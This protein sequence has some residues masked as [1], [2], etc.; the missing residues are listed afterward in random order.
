MENFLILQF[1][2]FAHKSLGK[3]IPPSSLCSSSIWFP[4]PFTGSDISPSLS[5][6]SLAGTSNGAQGHSCPGQATAGAREERAQTLVCGSA[7]E[8]TGAGRARGPERRAAPGDGARDPGGSRQGGSRALGAEASEA[9]RASGSGGCA[10]GGDVE[11]ARAGVGQRSSR[12]RLG[13]GAALV[14]VGS[15]AEVRWC[16]ARSAAAWAERVAPGG[17]AERPRR[18][19]GAKRG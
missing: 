9:A 8:W 7:R 11:L 10:G 16:G 15:R 13:H 5:L 14:Q 4:L 19:G 3:S 17:G 1:S 18:A 6:V 2:Y 12:R